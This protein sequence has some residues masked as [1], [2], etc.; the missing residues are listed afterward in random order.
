MIR[1][2]WSTTSIE[3]IKGVKEFPPKEAF[4]NVLTESDIS[5]VDYEHGMK[6]YSAF[7]CRDFLDY[8]KV[9]C[10]LDV[11]LMTEIVCGFRQ[12]MHHNFGLD[13]SHFMSLPAFSFDVMLKESGVKLDLISDPEMLL[14][15]ESG[16]RGG[17]SFVGTRHVKLPEDFDPNMTPKCLLYID[18]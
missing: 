2:Y 11:F 6:M 13:M 17:V 12:Q 1:S 7:E 16:L 10:L 8:C 18:T 9:Y 3:K 4:F 15:I 5:D 14:L